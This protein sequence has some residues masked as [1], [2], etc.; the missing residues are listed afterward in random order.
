[1]QK[2]KYLYLEGLRGLL[3]LIVVIHHF[4]LLFYPE[5]YYGSN[6]VSDYV[7]NADS[8]GMTLANTPLNIFMNGTWAVC[9]FMLL[10]GFV[11]S[12]RY[13]ESNDHGI[14]RASFFKRYF[15][16]GIPVLAAVLIIF[17][18][19]KFNVFQTLFYPRSDA[20][21]AFGK[22]L[23][24]KDI[25]FFSALRMGIIDVPL[26]GDNTYLPV[27]WTI[28]IELIG[29]LL[30]FAF[31]LITH[32][33]KY[34][35]PIFVAFIILLFLIN[36]SYYILIMTGSLIALF[37]E[38]IELN[39][40]KR[41]LFLILFLIGWYLEGIP[42]LQDVAKQ[43]TWYGYTTGWKNVFLHFQ[44]I[45]CA[46]IFIALL[47][48]K[49]I[50]AFLNSKPLQFLGSI[51]FSMYLLHLPILFIAGSKFLQSSKGQMN[52]FLLFLACLVLTMALSYIFFRLVDKN[53]IVLSNRL[54]K[55]ATKKDV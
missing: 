24:T 6:R 37:K 29:V 52:P 36:K 49:K 20:N 34:K 48:S 9:M 11:L 33:N 27:F 30:L 8:F 41:Y 5:V 39:S 46:L 22:E 1:M 53:A 40:H 16:L 3:A 42:N 23:F 14:I 32:D 47:S 54:G 31:L 18:L 26:N 43:Y 15:R 13:F 25:S 35:A 4:L 17:F 7:N 44:F 19:F 10:S 45:S 12:L 28:D 2:N 51:S 50:Q 21:Y 38:K 55:L